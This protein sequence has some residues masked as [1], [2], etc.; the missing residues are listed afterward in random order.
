MTVAVRW[1]IPRL[2][3]FKDASPEIAISLDA[4]LLDWEFNADRADIGLIYTRSPDRPNVSY[5]LLRRER[6]VA[7]CSSATAKA[8]SSPADIRQFP[9]LAV[10]G[11]AEDFIHLGRK[12]RA[13]RP[14]PEIL[15]C[16]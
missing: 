5:T 13:S 7:V 12:R 6:L 2:Q 1:L 8:I 16:F 15:A 10:T 4:S 14:Y 3:K 9:F 11:T